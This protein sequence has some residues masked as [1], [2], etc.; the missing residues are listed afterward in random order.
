[1]EKTI[2]I[3]S[4]KGMHA[5]LANKLVKASNKYDV[6]VRF[7]YDNTIINAKSI[8][9]LMSLAVPS[10]ENIKVVAEGDEAQAAIDEIE[11]LLG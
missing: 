9:G 2:T 8:L 4:T 1:M 3:K 7:Y 10:G 11:K 6:D 5:R